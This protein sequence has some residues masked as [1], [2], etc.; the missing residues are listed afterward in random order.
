MDLSKHKPNQMYVSRDGRI[1]GPVLHVSG[2]VYKVRV[3]FGKSYN[4][5]KTGWRHTAITGMT[6]PGDLIDLYGVCNTD[7]H[8]LP[9]LK[10]IVTPRYVQGCSGRLTDGLHEDPMDV[11]GQD[12]I[13]GRRRPSL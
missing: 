3:P 11:T 7:F 1:V 10:G 4:V 9:R 12:F 13:E 2:D 6:D 8:A 5:W